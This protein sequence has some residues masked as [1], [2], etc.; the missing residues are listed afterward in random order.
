MTE[1]FNETDRSLFSAALNDKLVGRIM[2]SDLKPIGC[3]RRQDVV[4]KVMNLD[5]AKNW[6]F[7]QRCSWIPVFLDAK[8]CRLVNI[9]QP[10]GGT[11]CLRSQG[12]IT[13][14]Y[15]GA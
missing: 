3:E 13:Y 15:R 1:L 11:H 14:R 5:V 10:F 9:Y 8:V 4:Y 6:G 12:C 7:S 2:K